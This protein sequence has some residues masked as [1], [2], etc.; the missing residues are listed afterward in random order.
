MSKNFELLQRVGSGQELFRRPVPPPGA[1]GTEAIP[2]LDK[3]AFEI[4]L[5]NASLPNVLE[6]AS[7]PED[8]IVAEHPELG[9]RQSVESASVITQSDVSTNVFRTSRNPA[10]PIGPVANRAIEEAANHPI[11]DLDRRAV[12]WMAQNATNPTSS[13]K[14]LHGKGKPRPNLGRPQ[15]APNATAKT[16]VQGRTSRTFSFSR[17]WL[18]SIKAGSKAWG[19]KLQ[20][21]NG[22]HDSS[23]E[24]ITRA[25]EIKL[26][27]RVFPETEQESQ[28]AVLFA[29]LDDEVGC[30]STCVR[31]AQVLAARAEG[32]VCV[33][34]ANFRTPSLH[35]YFGVENA[36]GLAESTVEAGPIQTFAQQVPE[37]DLWLIPSGNA[38]LRFNAMADGLRARM[39]ELRNTFR[40]VVIHS[41]PLRLETNAM[42]L[43]RWTDG[44]VLVLE[45]NKTRK[46]VVRRAR[47]ILAA[48]NVKVLGIVLNNRTFPIPDALYHRL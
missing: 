3:D 9:S 43:T 21:R 45:A 28:R 17:A 14:A 16:T 15:Q 1:A 23:L 11:E 34:D 22:H 32:P 13:G 40:Y 10:S 4:F 41:G 48:A 29:G 12:N 20:A 19:S 47:E 35:E 7:K 46:D 5:Q 18:G 33:V 30:A 25:E 8:P 6:T 44:I 37:P 42:L 36:N 24:T 27:Q 31:V 2:E 38:H 39:E 26:V